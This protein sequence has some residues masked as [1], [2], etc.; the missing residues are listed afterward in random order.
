MLSKR[1][2]TVT[3]GE[4]EQE[5]AYRTKCETMKWFCVELSS[6]AHKQTEKK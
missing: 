1:N 3:M 2:L 6:S 5:M 4:I